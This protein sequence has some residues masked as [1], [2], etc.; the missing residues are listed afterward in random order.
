LFTAGSVGVTDADT[1][2]FFDFDV[3]LELTLCP[4][5]PLE[6]PAP[7]EGVL[8]PPSLASFP[9]PPALPD[10]VVVAPP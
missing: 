8:L 4:A 9:L 10:A 2:S 5:R 3:E 1:Q 6:L 7:R